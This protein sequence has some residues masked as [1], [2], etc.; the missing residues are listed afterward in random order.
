MWRKLL[1]GGVVATLI[2]G[3]VGVYLLFRPVASVVSAAEYAPP[4]PTPKQ[5]EAVAEMNIFI[6]HQ[7][8]GRDML[9][10]MSTVFTEADVEPPQVVEASDLET[11]V[12]PGF[13][14]TFVGENGDPIGKMEAFDAAMRDGLG[15]VVDV[16]MLKFCYSDFHRGDDV[17][18]FF[19][20]YRRTMAALERDF[21]NVTFIYA[22]ASLTTE[23]ST[24][25][26]AKDRVKRLIGRAAYWPDPSRNVIRHSFNELIRAE[27][28]DSGRLFD[29]AAVQATG[30]DGRLELRSY[31]GGEYY[32]ME[33][34]LAADYGHHTP[35]GSARL[36]RAFV[37]TVANA[38][39]V[40]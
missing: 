28:A 29:L 17:E 6:G 32:S 1:A 34:S 31:R 37:A 3:A 22:T 14:H 18:R 38:T 23:G 20:E 39:N 12:G 33:R 21:P 35:A 30:T 26:R 13:V 15:D 36:A 7:S 11:L 24:F 19:D 8:V 2:A 25:E 4:M 27:Y 9:S 40:G 16:A 10:T 5:V